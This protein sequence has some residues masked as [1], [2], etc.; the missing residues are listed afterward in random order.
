MDTTIVM[1]VA[2]YKGQKF[3]RCSYLIRQYYDDEELQQ[4]PPDEI[5]FEKAFREIKT[6]KPIVTFYDLVWDEDKNLP[7]HKLQ[8]DD[9]EDFDMLADNSQKLKNEQEERNETIKQLVAQNDVEKDSGMID[10]SEN[11]VE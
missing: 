7:H 6:E 4:N 3:F 5:V 9:F 1:I 2:S 10:E 8:G 11:E